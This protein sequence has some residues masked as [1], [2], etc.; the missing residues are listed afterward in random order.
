M[1]TGKVS[2]SYTKALKLQPY[3]VA[4]TEKS[5]C[6]VRKYRENKLQVLTKTDVTYEWSEVQTQNLHHRVH[7]ELRNELMGKL[8][9][10]LPFI[11]AN[12]V[13][14]HEET[15]ITNNGFDVT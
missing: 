8:F 5:I 10:L 2:T 9:L 13:K 15:S 1:C 6:R 3:K 12:K 7:H 14:I 4:A 11:I